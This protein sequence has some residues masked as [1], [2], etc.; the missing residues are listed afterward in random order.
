MMCFPLGAGGT[1]DLTIS[2][3]PCS[4]LGEEGLPG[5]EEK[6]DFR[7]SRKRHKKFNATQ[8]SSFAHMGKHSQSDWA[9]TQLPTGS[10]ESPAYFAYPLSHPGML[11]G[12][13]SGLQAVAPPSL[14]WDV[15]MRIDAHCICNDTPQKQ[16]FCIDEAEISWAH[17]TLPKPQ[18]QE[19]FLTEWLRFIVVSY[20]KQQDQGLLN[21]VLLLIYKCA[22]IQTGSFIAG[23]MKQ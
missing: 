17:S 13:N 16:L 19:S 10:R 2:E 7:Y 8:F 4:G 14:H 20:L 6:G 22:V 15:H 23:Y 11:K 5:L 18:P 12:K 3:A 21:H 1:W 9:N